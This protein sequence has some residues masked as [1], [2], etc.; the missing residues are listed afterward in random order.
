MITGGLDGVRGASCHQG[1]C[2]CWGLTGAI[3]L[4]GPRG[5][6]GACVAAG[7]GVVPGLSCSKGNV[8][9]R[10]PAGAVVQDDVHGPC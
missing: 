6:E 7:A 10:G 1:L 3:L 2:G 5:S 4:P 8:C 9:V